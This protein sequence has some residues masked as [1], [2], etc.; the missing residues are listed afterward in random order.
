MRRPAVSILLAVRNEQRHLPA[1]LASLQ[2]QTLRDWELIAVNDGSRDRTGAI[3]R[4]AAQSDPRIRVFNR[5]GRGL[6]AAL[7]FGL[8]HCRASLIARMDGDDRCHPRRLE[9]QARFLRLHPRIGL[10]ATAVRH[11]PA[12]RI[13]EGL[14][15]YQEWQNALRRPEEIRRDLYVESPFAHPSVMLRRDILLRVGGYQERP[16]AEDYDLWL[17][18]ARAGVRFARLPQVL[19]DWR[20]R[21]Q[22]LTRTAPTCTA[23]A[24][25]AC[26]IHH[27]QQDFLHQVGEVSL[28]GAGLEGKAWR[29]ALAEAGIAVTRWLD[30]DPRKI[31][32]RIH[33]APVHS[34][35]TLQPDGP[36]VLV[37]IGARG[38]RPQVRAWARQRNLRE[39]QDFLIVT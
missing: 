39:G 20:D 23:A 1:A 31:G 12:W 25:R 5:P 35:D 30:V 37:T 21:P 4:Q 19:L 29:K 2:A 33:G 26:K 38:A 6:V 15:A 27:L 8:R 10:V 36:P 24:F 28:W 9:L 22:R 3:L 16:W 7:N 32:Q 11:F 17:R 13:K 18:L 14:R 34:I